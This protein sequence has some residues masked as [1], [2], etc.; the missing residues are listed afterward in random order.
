[1]V[2]AFTIQPASR[3][4]RLRWDLRIQGPEEWKAYNEA[5]PD[6]AVRISATDNPDHSN[7]YEYQQPVRTVSQTRCN[8]GLTLWLRPSAKAY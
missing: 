4:L 5:P 2:G 8:F 7:S 3:S 1:M 6:A